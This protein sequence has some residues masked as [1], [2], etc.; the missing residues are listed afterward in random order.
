MSNKEKEATIGEQVVEEVKKENPVT[1]TVEEKH[2]R[3]EE[4]A[5][6][7]ENLWTYGS[8]VLFTEGVLE[9][10][11]VSEKNRLTLSFL[12]ISESVIRD[13]YITITA[14]DEE[15]N[16]ERLQ[17]S[18]LALGQAY[19]KIKGRAAKL[20]IS[21]ENAR[22]FNIVID[23]AIFENGSIWY[24]EDAKLESTGI[25][26]DI[27][28][29]AQAK[30]KD[31][32]D[33]YVAA[34]EALSKDD[35]ASIK[36]A[37]E[38]LKRIQWY[39]DGEELFKDAQTKYQIAKTN[40]ERKQASEDRRIGREKAVKK[41]YKRAAFIGIL[42][43]LLAI[44]SVFLYFIP[45]ESYKAAKA[46]LNKQDY[47]KASKE[48]EALKGFLKSED[49]LAQ[50]YYNIG[51]ASLNEGDEEKAIEYFR[52]SHSTNAKA[53]YGI[54]TGAFLDYYA[55]MEAMEAGK[56]GEAFKLFEGS[57]N[58][59]TDFNLSNKANA[60]MAQVYYYQ[61]DYQTAW[62]TINNVYT[63]DSAYETE[64]GMIGY[65]HAKNLIETD[66][67]KEGIEIYNK[68]SKLTNE[69]DL[70]KTVYEKAV[71]L[72]EDAKIDECKDL[73]KQIKDVYPE[74]DKLYEHITAFEEKS[75]L[76]LGTWRHKNKSGNK[77]KYYKIHI[78]QVLYKGEMC[79]RIQD[80]NNK[81][82]GFDTIISKKNN[83][84]QI[85]IGT[86]ML[87]FKLKK[88]HDQKFTYI[89]KSGRKFVRE[90]KYNGNTYKS[91][92]KLEEEKT[93]KKTDKKKN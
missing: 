47:V 13:L 11:L 91:K 43:I 87:K 32:E 17:H 75:E 89:M 58:A 52:K 67:F 10:D 86:Y 63:K 71:A 92:Y 44:A 57:A 29:F 9:K 93:T 23:K 54:M 6:L 35:S 8:P 42:I 59:A 60:G 2:T 88:F 64:Y 20:P 16:V 79:L 90:L 12:N 30:A 14:E 73:L 65:G 19:L 83:V 49:Y 18:Y 24:K 68:V 25:I 77:T 38:I 70:G 26:E 72:G 78:S 22:K 61:G 84:T 3:Y 39:K 85:Q 41:K 74:A 27:D 55:G 62:T 69:A 50:C 45:N 81:T 53:K 46:T 76:W 1:E 66:K 5:R 82:L 34:T 7:D 28:V 21:N 51:L 15:G 56:Y 48:F 37:V 36:D 40:E 33:N 31:Y 80:Q 4:L